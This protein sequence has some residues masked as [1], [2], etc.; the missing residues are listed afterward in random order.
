MS[1]NYSYPPSTVP[2]PFDPSLQHVLPENNLSRAQICSSPQVAETLHRQG[3]T[4]GLISSMTSSVSSFPLRIWIV[5][6]S[7]SMQ[8]TD[9]SKIAG[10]RDNLKFVPSSR[11]DE[12]RECIIYHAE[13]AGLLHSSTVFRMLNIP[14]VHAGPQMMSI[15]E[16]GPDAVAGEVDTVRNCMYK[17]RPGGCTPLAQHLREIRE[18]VDSMSTTLRAGGQKVAVIIATDGLPTDSNGY[19]SKSTRDEFVNELMLL[20]RLPVWIVVRLCTDDE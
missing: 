17:S 4:K 11:W 3:Y 14:G 8:Q 2:L 12:I 1:D 19:Q 7:G 13:M 5:D 16:R 6:N 15:A 18:I 9:G 20:G 10:N